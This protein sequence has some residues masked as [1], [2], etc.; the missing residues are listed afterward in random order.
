MKV[1]GLI[2]ALFFAF[3][4]L[5]AIAYALLAQEWVGTAALVL[6]GGLAFIIA[7]YLLF[8]GRR[9]DPRPEDDHDAEVSDGAGEVGF[10]SP[11][12]WWPLAVVASAAVVTVGAVFG[13]W[14]VGIGVILLMTSLYGFVFEYYRGQRV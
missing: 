14:I 2:F 8:T 1:E 10:F 12:S 7:F 11:H 5:I 13:W 3:F 9:I 6:A 4:E